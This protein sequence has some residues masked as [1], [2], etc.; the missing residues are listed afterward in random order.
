[1][2]D[3]TQALTIFEPKNV[4]TLAEIAPKSL[5]ENQVS[6]A[7]CLEVGNALLLRVKKEGMSDALDIEIA[8]FIEKAKITVKKM[9]G[10]RTPVTQLFDQIRKVYTSME[11]EVDPS[12]AASIPNQLQAYRNAYAKKK[13]EEEERRRR[14][15]A[16]RQAKENAKVRYRADV[17][18]DYVNQFN[19]LVNKSINELTDMD[20]LLTLDNYEIIYDGVKEYLCEFPDTWCQNVISGA[21]RPAE[22]TPDEC[23][24]IQANVMA[25]MV[26][27]FKEQF[28][29]EVQSTRDDILDRLPSKKKELE[30]MAKASAE[31]AAKIKADMEAKER[32][33]A[34]RKEVERK[35][36]EKQEAA[37]AQLASKKQEMDG[38]FG[39]P[40]ATPV[41]YQPKKQVKKIVV[42]ET[43]EDIMKVVAFWWSQ[44]G[45]TKTV[46]ELCKEF[47]KQITYANNAANSKDAPM[48]ISDVRYEDEVK[49]K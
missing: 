44:E 28:P 31:D 40:V 37:A 20:K 47:K 17:E 42:I 39:L 43:A 33:E 7:R 45:C 2:A 29:F 1:M 10:K 41:G 21:H 13:H 46:D 23:R 35:E 30:R 15:E 12:K 25:G 32:E 14:E 48:F 24:A 9:N 22:L 6:H 27:R 5:Q 8:N 36:R 34:V 26:N 38:L 49:A 4:Q 19:A 16:A 18:E 11:N 3:N